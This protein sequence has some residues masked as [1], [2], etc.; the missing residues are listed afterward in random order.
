MN[1]ESTILA[2]L[3]TLFKS[4][5]TLEDYIAAHNPTDIFHVEQLQRQYDRLIKSH[6]YW[7]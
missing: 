2:A 7:S 5:P 6:P 1:S 3:K 4:T